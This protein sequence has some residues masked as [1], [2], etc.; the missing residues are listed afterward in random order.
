VKVARSV[1]G[2]GKFVRI[3]LSQQ[4]RWDSIIKHEKVAYLG[5]KKTR[6]RGM[7]KNR[8]IYGRGII[9]LEIVRK[10]KG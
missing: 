2:G 9:F 5:G 6:T 1:L 8:L 3:Y 10:I 4:D 7:I